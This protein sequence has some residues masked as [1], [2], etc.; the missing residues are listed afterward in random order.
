MENSARERTKEKSEIEDLVI[1]VFNNDIPVNKG[2]TVKRI[3]FEI[4]RNRPKDDKLLYAEVDSAVVSLVEQDLLDEMRSYSVSSK[5][6]S[7]E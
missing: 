2:A 5:R 3:A 4:N 1:D 7:K 6:S